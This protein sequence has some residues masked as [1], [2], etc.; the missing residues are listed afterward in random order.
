MGECSESSD[1]VLWEPELLYLLSLHTRT[2]DSYEL[3][4]IK[5]WVHIWVNRGSLDIRC[6]SSERW[7]NYGEP[8]DDSTFT[9]KLFEQIGSRKYSVLNLLI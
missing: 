6:F 7:N 1:S 5:T 9:P 2:Q 8:Y 4:N 3:Y